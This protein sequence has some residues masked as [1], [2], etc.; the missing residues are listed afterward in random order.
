MGG[1]VV[2]NVML[3]RKHWFVMLAECI[4]ERWMR[5]KRIR[6]VACKEIYL[7]M[8]INPETGLC[9]RCEKDFGDFEPY[10]RRLWFK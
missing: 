8:Y 1:H 7:M 9:P 2:V 4:L 10:I 5:M 3:I 6:C